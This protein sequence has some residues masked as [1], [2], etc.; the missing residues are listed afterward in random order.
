MKIFHLKNDTEYFK[1]EII[2]NVRSAKKQTYY[3]I[4]S[5]KKNTPHY[6]QIYENVMHNLQINVTYQY[7]Y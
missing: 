2:I 4:I 5:F 3:I 6:F 1:F 7:Y